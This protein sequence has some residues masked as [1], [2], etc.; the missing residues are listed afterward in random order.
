MEGKWEFYRGYGKTYLVA[1]ALFIWVKNLSA[2]SYVTIRAGV[3]PLK[4]T[5]K[6]SNVSVI[7]TP[8]VPSKRSVHVVFDTSWSEC[9]PHG[10]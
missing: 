1:V 9:T 3:E 2:R 10:L 6:C 8:A 5:G 4:G 7:N